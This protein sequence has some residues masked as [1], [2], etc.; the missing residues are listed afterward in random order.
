MM[1]EKEIN[2]QLPS[3]DYSW[4]DVIPKNDEELRDHLQ[5]FKIEINEF[6]YQHLPKT[7]TLEEMEKLAVAI[8]IRIEQ[9]WERAVRKHAGAVPFR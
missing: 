7:T 5:N 6:L 8:C 3:I 2:R 9:E 1:D 4:G